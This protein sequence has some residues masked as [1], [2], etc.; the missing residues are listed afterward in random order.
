[1]ETQLKRRLTLYGLVMIAVGSCI[2]AGI[3]ATPN[4]VVQDVPH[5]GWALAA[6]VLGGII[7]LT[8]ALTMAELG[9]MYPQAG[10]VYVF[11]K[12]A[13][14]R[15]AGF[16]YGWVML[17][18]INAGALAALSLIFADY[19]Q[20]FLPGLGEKGKVWLAVGTIFGLTGMNIL[21][22]QISQ[23]FA[24]L[25]TGLKLLALGGIVFV[26][27]FFF[28]EQ[29]PTLNLDLT[30]EAPE[31][32]GSALLA[33]LIGVL[34]SIG[35]WHHASYVAGEAVEPRRT[36]PR[37]MVLAALIVTLVYVLANLGYMLMLPLPELQASTAVAGDALLKFTPTGGK[38]A[39]LIIAVSIFGTI[40]VY[41]MTAPRIYFAMA[42]DGVFF[43][44]L[45]KVHPRFRTPF[46]AMLIQ[47]VWASVLLLFWETFHN[48]IAYVTF[49][50]IAFM[51]L[52][53]AGLFV[54]R[55]TRPEHPRPF[56]V[57]GYPFV[58]LI[59]VGISAAFV[60]NMLVQ[61]PQQAWA[62]LALLGLGA[63]AWLAFNKQE[64]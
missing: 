11:L 34:F 54:L 2:G 29:L 5:H 19:M 44:G 21:G 12:E 6:W 8:G 37:A 58:P 16:L 31:N 46:N 1:M 42:R 13:Y 64:K 56:R 14:G 40:G 27:L 18:V 35:G 39:A 50:D 53:G 7:A 47:V 20:F 28:G 25:F 49:M 32:L 43:Q 15:L 41:T 61:R 38:I 60:I 22:V 59:F 57:W 3:F 48:L 9:G 55:R 63:L 30:R 45:A 10:G 4:V 17:L 52:A 33:G 26:G 23:L 62:G 51:A 24:N 36:V